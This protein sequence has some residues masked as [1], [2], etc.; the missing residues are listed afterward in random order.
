M[1]APASSSLD[2][3]LGFRF[4]VE[5][6][7]IQEAY[8]TECSGLQASTEVTEYK[9]GGFNTGS[10]KL[11][12]R[13]TFTNITLKH[14]VSGSRELIKWYQ[15]LLSKGFAAEERKNVSI[16]VYN[17]VLEEQHRWNLT[18]VIPVKWIGPNF[19]PSN[20]TVAIETLELAFNSVSSVTG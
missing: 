7:G 12:V 1:P 6:G 9:E 20:S 17:S 11:P 18:D 10:H 5:V 8:F 13:T 3:L 2:P 19:D 14:G 4:A 16:V 15:R